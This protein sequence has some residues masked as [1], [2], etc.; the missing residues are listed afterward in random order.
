MLNLDTKIKG[1]YNPALQKHMETADNK[2]YSSDYEESSEEHQG[3][4]GSSARGR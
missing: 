3:R 4:R 1:S 2:W